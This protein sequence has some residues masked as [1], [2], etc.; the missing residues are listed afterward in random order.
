[1]QEQK[2]KTKKKDA[3]CHKNYSNMGCGQVDG[4]YDKS[5]PLYVY[6]YYL[7]LVPT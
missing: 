7:Y 6:T 5:T 1:M 3:S 4:K 2:K